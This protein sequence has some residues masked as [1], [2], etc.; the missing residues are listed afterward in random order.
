MPESAMMFTNPIIRGFNPDPSICRVGID[1]YLATSSFAYF[2]GIPVYHSRD[3]VNWRLVGHALTRETQLP[4]SGAGIKQG[5]W[6]PTLRFHAGRFY[7]TATRM[8]KNG[9][10]N[11]Y[12]STDDPS[13]E[14]SEPVEVDQKGIDPDL[15]FDDDGRV[16]YLSTHP[17]PELPGS[18][19]AMAEIDIETGQRLTD[20]RPLWP[21]TGGLAP[22][23]P[24]LYKIRG[25]YYLMIA[26]GGTYSGHMET[27]A[28]SRQVWG[29]YA[30]CPH[31]PIL[32]HRNDH[33]LPIQSAGHADLVEAHDGSWWMVHL[34][35]RQTFYQKSQL[36]RETFLTPVTWTPDGW[37]LVNGGRGVTELESAGPKLPRHPWPA[38][39]ARD[40]FGGPA[41]GPHWIFLR[42]PRR[43][44]YDLASRPGW[45]RLH[46]GEETLVEPSASPTFVC[47]RQT[48]PSMRV[49]ARIDFAGSREESEAGLTVFMAPDAFYQF[50]IGIHDGRRR[51]F[52][53]RRLD[54]L[55]V[56]SA[57]CDAP[58][59]H[60]DLA[61]ESTA[62]EYVFSTVSADGNS[63]IIDRATSRYLCAEVADTFSGA[64]I[65]VFADNATADFGAFEFVAQSKGMQLH[66]DLCEPIG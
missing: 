11:F 40:G 3:L 9:P 16:Y 17:L 63:T 25:W 54:D 61:I 45:L 29:P 31:N 38:Q 53:R 20:I 46:G 66:D 24:H 49:R 36:G 64:M 7:A 18:G 23:G 62:T 52:V 19:I 21:G 2:P 26:E 6:A 37:P 15:F 43:E 58:P 30:P 8:G 48:Q 60:V 65:G 50:G 59:G 32:T 12:V 56:I 34:G 28:R 22:E 57:V 14:W 33:S 39:P 47:R 4:L 5:I 35:I 10:V 51:V 42:N 13:G 41:L 44:R 1:Y 27:I 55:T